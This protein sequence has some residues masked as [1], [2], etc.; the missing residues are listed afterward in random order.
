MRITYVGPHDAV[1]VPA[2]RAIV[3][4]D[5]SVD[6][7]DEQAWRLLEQRGN[8]AKAVEPKATKKDGAS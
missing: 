8:W 2:I 4:R 1:E 6:V 7:P 3:R 5:E